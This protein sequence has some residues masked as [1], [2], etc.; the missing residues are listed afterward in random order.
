MRKLKTVSSL[1][2]R[3]K[4]T[5]RGK[6]L[7]AHGGTSHNNAYKSKSRKR[8]LRLPSEVTPTES[9]RLRRLLPYS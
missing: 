9:R 1:K 8:R 3:I 5:G 2:K 4:I 6:F 7:H